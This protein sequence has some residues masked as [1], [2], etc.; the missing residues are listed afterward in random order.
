M[1]A[2]II[3]NIS[4]ANFIIY[5]Y[6]FLAINSIH[7]TSLALYCEIPLPLFQYPQH[8]SSIFCRIKS[9]DRWSKYADI[10]NYRSILLTLQ[11]PGLLVRR[12]SSNKL[13]QSLP[14]TKTPG[15]FS[16]AHCCGVWTVKFS[17]LISLVIL[18]F[19][20]FVTSF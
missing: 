14:H 20:V 8:K 15:T 13:T 18:Y 12:T 5:I 16:A 17:I 7:E 19:S 10:T 3:N 6:F 4:K 11:A 1:V 9:F 2:N